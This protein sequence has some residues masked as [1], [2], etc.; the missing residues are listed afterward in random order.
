MINK[1]NIT[2]INKRVVLHLFI[3]VNKNMITNQNI[4]ECVYKQNYRI[5]SSYI[6]IVV[7]SCRITSPYIS[8]QKYDY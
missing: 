2:N 3:L 8:Q 4:E 7:Y 1:Q 6:T 5:M